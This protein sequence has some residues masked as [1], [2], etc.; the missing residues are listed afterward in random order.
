MI[1]E[2]IASLGN[3]SNSAL[4]SLFRSGGILL[5]LLWGL[6][7]AAVLIL[8]SLALPSLVG[9]N[10]F[11][12]ELLDSPPEKDLIALYLPFNIFSGLAADNFPAVVLY[13]TILGVL[14]QKQP[15]RGQLL[16]ILKPLQDLFKASNSLV[17][18]I[19]PLGIFALS[20]NTFAKLEPG[21]LLRLQGFA[22]ICLLALVALSMILLALLLSFTP[23]TLRQIWD[24]LKGPLAITAS[25]SNLLIA[26][27]LLSKNLQLLL[28]KSDSSEPCEELTAVISVGFAL[29]MLG[30]VASLLFLPFAAWYVNQPIGAAAIANM[31]ATGIPSLA[32]GLKSAFRIE[33]LQ[34]GLPL[35]LMN[36]VYVNSEWLYRFE[37]VLSLEGLVVLAILVVG[38]SHGLLHFRP[39]L[40][41]LGLGASIA[42]SALLGFGL[43]RSLAASLKGQYRNANT[44]LNLKP[45]VPAAKPQLVSTTRSE[46][47]NLAAIRSR[48][49]LRV[50]V[51]RDGLPWAYRN[52]QGRL[53]G[54][55]V[56]LAQSLAKSLGVGI[57]WRQSN[58]NDLEQLLNEQKIDLALGGIQASPERAARFS[59][60]QGY[61]PVHLALVVADAM[62]PKIESLPH[63]PLGRPLVVAV[64]DP[65]LLNQQVR[66]NI[67]AKLGSAEQPLQIDLVLLANKEAFFSKANKGRYDA[68]LTPAEGGASWAVT[69]P[70]YSVITPFNKKLSNELVILIGGRDPALVNYTNA[71]LNREQQQGLITNLF[72]HWIRVHSSP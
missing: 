29:P 43:N 30:Q 24:L 31:L 67:T 48:G 64:S 58:I 72:S 51:R 23:Y 59:I 65:E 37:K 15:N 33:L 17:A 57:T 19:I 10:F 62:I 44:L 21:Q 25:S 42:S 41:S 47:V 35:D 11:Y 7:A 54:F 1:C 20:L 38:R 6:A 66:E 46:P 5:L 3:L 36:L 63:Q 61:L 52:Q 8:P 45:L 56:D 50:G 12:P 16:T 60:S 68:W 27:P 13:S 69:H 49:V 32:G 55:D 18:K 28:Q 4:R 14:L 53:V 40:L 34:L 9:S 2:L 70:D 22:L 71:W 26:L 39:L